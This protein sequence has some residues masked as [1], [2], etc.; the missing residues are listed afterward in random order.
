MLSAS[1]PIFAGEFQLLKFVVKPG[2]FF[3]SQKKQPER[4]SKT[5]FLKQLNSLNERQKK[6]SQLLKLVASQAYSLI[7]EFDNRQ[8]FD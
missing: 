5:F 7:W 4:I 6:D 8:S 3:E 1:P 2:L